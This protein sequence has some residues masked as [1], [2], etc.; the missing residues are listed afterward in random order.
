MRSGPRPTNSCWKVIIPSL[1]ADSVLLCRRA[2]MVALHLLFSGM[3]QRQRPVLH[4]TSTPRG[5]AVT[6]PVRWPLPRIF[7]R[8]PQ[9]RNPRVADR[10]APPDPA[11]AVPLADH[12]A[13]SALFLLRL[14][15]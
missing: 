6:G 5:V 15:G 4:R 10:F 3:R 2:I 13:R 12:L 8:E 9:R 11:P 1:M 7:P 14:R